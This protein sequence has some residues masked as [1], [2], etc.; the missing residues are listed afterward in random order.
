MQRKIIPDV[1][2]GQELSFASPRATIRE[3]AQ[4][5]ARRRIG[6]IM[7]LDEQRLVGIFTERDLAAKV[8]AIGLNPD[9]TPVSAVMT[10]DPDT[11]A[12]DDT[13]HQA[14]TMMRASGY[15]HLPVVDR[16]RVVAMVS[17]R[18]LYDTVLC[19]LEDDL[20]DRDAFI[21]GVGY[22]LGN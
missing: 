3:A 4:T 8:V 22:G 17:V 1:V 12:P 10:R 15:R 21:H 6:A 13:A 7:V 9:T 18:D 16:G 11:L 5:M 19:E 20:R 2:R 14:L